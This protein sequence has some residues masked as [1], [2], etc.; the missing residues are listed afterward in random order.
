VFGD[1]KF[2]MKRDELDKLSKRA[3][4]VEWANYSIAATVIKLFNSS[5][6]NIANA[7][8]SSVYIN[9]RTP[10]RGKFIDRSRL[11][12]GRQS[13]PYRIGPLFSRIDFN[14]AGIQLSEDSIRRSLKRLFF[15]YCDPK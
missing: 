15:N 2:K 12:I 1:F 9:D 13:L 8:R 5:D 4:P 11:K 14:W 6:C 7:L 10:G 3:T